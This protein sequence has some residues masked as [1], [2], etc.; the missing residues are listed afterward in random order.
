MFFTVNSS[1]STPF[2]D[3]NCKAVRVIGKF[4]KGNVYALALLIASLVCRIFSKKKSE[5]LYSMAG[6]QFNKGGHCLTSYFNYKSALIDFSYNGCVIP[7]SSSTELNAIRRRYGSDVVDYWL[8]IGTEEIPL[9]LDKIKRAEHGVCLGMSLDFIEQY[10]LRIKAGCLPLDA[11]REVSSRYVNGAPEKAQ[12]AQIFYIAVCSAQLIAKEKIRLDHLLNENESKIKLWL[13]E[14]QDEARKLPSDQLSERL[15]AVSLELKTRLKDFKEKGLSMKICG[16]A[17][18]E[19]QRQVEVC[20][21]FGLHFDPSQ[22]YATDT[23]AK[24][25]E[26]FG[27]F[28][29]AIPDGCYRGIFRAKGYAHATVLIKWNDNY[30]LFDPNKGTLVFESPAIY[31]KLWQIGKDCFNKHGICSFSVSKASLI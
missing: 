23:Y 11:I 2:C 25:D 29:N 7:P 17:Q 4:L 27:H 28:I 9:K 12:I 19:E 16:I 8:Q 24:Y 6:F 3:K 14:Q 5:I 15:N 30:C 21:R 18:V 26:E 31:K 22:I 13:K 10:L 20:N 1:S